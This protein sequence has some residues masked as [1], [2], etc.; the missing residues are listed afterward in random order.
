MPGFVHS[1]AKLKQDRQSFASFYATLKKYLVNPCA[2]E[3]IHAMISEAVSIERELVKDLEDL[4]NGSLS[5]S[6]VSVDF[7]LVKMHVMAKGDEV[8]RLLEVAPLF[9]GK[10]PLAWVELAFIKER[11]RYIKHEVVPF[12]N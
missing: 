12:F 9:G 8:C 6:N 1:I 5:L 7:E 11:D 10:D 3:T 4:S 2:V